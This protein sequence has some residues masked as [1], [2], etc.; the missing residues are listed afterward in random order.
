[1]P[2]AFGHWMIVFMR[3]KRW[4]EHRVW[5]K[6]LMRLQKAGVLK[7]SAAFMDRNVKAHHHAA[8]TRKKGL[9]GV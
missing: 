7:V 2:E 6:A 1:M 8:G 4:F 9:P 3:Y 5:W